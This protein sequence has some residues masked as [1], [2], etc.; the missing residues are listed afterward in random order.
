M[1][2]RQSSGEYPPADRLDAIERRADGLSERIAATERSLADGRVAFTEL[3]GEIKAAVVA[4]DN[5]AK[6]VQ[7][8]MAER[9]GYGQKAVEAVIFWAVPLLGGA[10]L[11][12]I[13]TSG[14]IPAGVHP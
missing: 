9:S 12:A 1:P 5:L 4:I 3:R 14:Q 11:W 10:A 7:Q 2:P 6:Q 13:K 8:A